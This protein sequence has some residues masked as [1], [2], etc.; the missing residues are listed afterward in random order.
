MEPHI[1][2]N[3]SLLLADAIIEQK[4]DFGKPLPRQIH[5]VKAKFEIML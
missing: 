3:S 1:L 4:P 5:K 2:S